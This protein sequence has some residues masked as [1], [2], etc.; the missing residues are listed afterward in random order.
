MFTLLVLSG[1]FERG[2]DDGRGGVLDAFVAFSESLSSCLEKLEAMLV[3][4]MACLPI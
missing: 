2:C 3:M 1:K 4:F